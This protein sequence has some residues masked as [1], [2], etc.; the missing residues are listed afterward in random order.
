VI[1]VRLDE[2]TLLR[3]QQTVHL[4]IHAVTETVQLR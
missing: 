1:P 2:L 4:P 3:L